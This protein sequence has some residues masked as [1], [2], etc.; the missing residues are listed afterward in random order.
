MPGLYLEEQ[1]CRELNPTPE[2][3]TDLSADGAIAIS[4]QKTTLALETCSD[5]ADLSNGSQGAA[6]QNKV[7]TLAGTQGT[8]LLGGLR[9]RPVSGGDD[10]LYNS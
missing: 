7:C 10:T 2:R 9:I 4:S 6:F 1:T 5:G 8:H 3:Q